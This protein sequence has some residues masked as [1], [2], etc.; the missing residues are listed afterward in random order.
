[1]VADRIYVDNDTLEE[2]YDGS[3][4]LKN[5]NTHRK[6]QF[7]VAMALGY[8]MGKKLKLEKRKEFFLTQF[9]N[10][11]DLTLLYALAI[12]E[13]NDINVVE[14]LDKVYGIAEEYANAG[15]RKLYTM[16]KDSAIENF[17]KRFEKVMKQHI[18]K[19]NLD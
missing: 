2:M 3:R 6:D 12:D 1:M 19:L 13:T 5:K 7:F 17:S 18:T 10:E 9:L 15:I 4:F 14:D 16:E 8:N 11:Q